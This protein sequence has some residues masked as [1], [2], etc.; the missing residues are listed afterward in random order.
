MPKTK[1]KGRKVR[2]LKTRKR[3]GGCLD[4]KCTL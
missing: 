1:R 3:R 4:G 2:K